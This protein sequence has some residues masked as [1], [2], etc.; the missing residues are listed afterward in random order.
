MRLN[1]TSPLFLMLVFFSV[2][3]RRWYSVSI[4]NCSFMT[5]YHET[6]KHLHYKLVLLQH[7]L[8]FLLSFN[9]AS[10]SS[11]TFNLYNFHHDSMALNL[12]LAG[13]FFFFSL[14]LFIF[15]ILILSRIGRTFC[16]FITYPLGVLESGTRFGF[17]FVFSH[18][19][20]S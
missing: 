11:V 6:T 7:P 13:S 14:S 9:D 19:E 17:K 15:F 18:I 1:F 10:Q 3:F 8:V 4:I 5:L 16:L 2:C 12:G 20:G